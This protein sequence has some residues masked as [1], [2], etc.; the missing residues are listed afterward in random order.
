MPDLPDLPSPPRRR[1]DRRGRGLRGPLLPDG[2]P[3][4][5][6]RGEQFDELVVAELTRVARRFRA[7]LVDLDLLVDDV[8]ATDDADEVRLFRTS[9]A[10]DGRRARLVVHR[11]PVESRSQGVRAREDLVH[12]VVVEAVAELLGLAPEDVDPDHDD[13]LP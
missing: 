3:A 1:R 12:H 2:L 8:P 9:P 11:R 13:D 6:S 10:T 4:A 5:R 7:E